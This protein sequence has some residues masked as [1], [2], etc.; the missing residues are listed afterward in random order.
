MKKKVSIGILTYNHEQFIAQ[1]LESC[2]DLKYQNLQIIISDDAS[3]DKTVEVITDILKNLHSE[4]EIIFIKNPQN[5]GLAGNFNKT[6]YETADGDFLITL[7]GDDII[8]YDYIQEALDS[9]VEYPE[10]VMIDFNATVIDQNNNVISN[11]EHLDFSTKLYSLDDYI[12][13]NTVKS[14]APA[15][16]LKR[17]LVTSFMP[18][19]TNCP[20]EDTVLV[21]RAVLAGKLLRVDKRVVLYRKHTGNISNIS[22]MKKM[23]H[24]K[25]IAQ[26]I[27]DVLYW[28]EKDL[29]S[30]ELI[31]KLFIRFNFEYK[32]RQL[33]YSSMPS[34]IKVLVM[35][36]NKMLYK[37]QN[38]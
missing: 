4:H 33:A 26:Y 38:K 32:R 20:T 19:S 28:Y 34:K 17:E 25:T 21:L 29:I 11:H 30:E 37:I 23:S 1:C 35:K 3:K 22:S 24:F 9:F 18:I 6:F 12:Y 15:R 16:I 27:R 8:A 13:L 31:K 14:F 5:L 10:A 2:L 36:L 7:G